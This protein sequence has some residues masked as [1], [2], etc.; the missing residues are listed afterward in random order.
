MSNK[1]QTHGR[2]AWRPSLTLRLALLGGAFVVVIV[3]CLSWVF[4]QSQQALERTARADSAVTGHIEDIERHT[5]ELRAGI[6]RV[7]TQVLTASERAQAMS[8]QLGE[9]DKQRAALMR[10]DDAVA[11]QW[12][13]V[14][15]LTRLQ[16]MMDA[17]ARWIVAPSAGSAASARATRASLGEMLS[18]LE[19]MEVIASSEL[20][21]LTQSIDAISRMA[22]RTIST[23][24]PDLT[25]DLAALYALSEAPVAA[26]QKARTDA[27]SSLFHEKGT[28]VAIARQASTRTA[29]L[30]RESAAAR[31]SA[32]FARATLEE[33][34]AQQTAL[35]RAARQQDDHRE[36]LKRLLQGISLNILIA[37]VVG[38][39]LAVV[40]WLAVMRVVLRP[41]RNLV[42]AMS[43]VGREGSWFG[44]RLDVSHDDL[45]GRLAESFNNMLEALSRSTVSTRFQNSVLDS[46]NEMLVVLDADRRVVQA[47]RAFRTA[48]GPDAGGLTGLPIDHLLSDSADGKAGHKVLR[49]AGND[50]IPI[51]VT[52]SEIPKVEGSPG[53][54]VL[55]A[56]DIRERLES[57]AA[58]RAGR[59]RF[60]DFADSAADWYWEMDAQ[61]RFSFFSDRFEKVTGVE[62][63]QLLGKTR[64]ETGIPNV[65]IKAWKAHLKALDKRV[66]FRDF[67]HPRVLKSGETVWLSI[68]GTPVYGDR[69]EFLGYRG[70]GSDVTQR[71]NAVQAVREAKE[72]ADESVRTK[73]NFLANVSHEIRTPING[74][75]GM[76]ELL[77]RSELDPRQERHARALL[78]S[79]QALLLQVNDL[80]DFARLESGKLQLELIPFS[81]EELVDEV[82][83]SHVELAAQHDLALTSECHSTIDQLL[84]DPYRIRQ[85][86]TNFISNALKFTKTGQIHIKLKS[87]PTRGNRARMVCEVIDTGIGIGP[88]R[89]DRVFDAFVQADGS[90]TREFGGTGLGLS[91]CKELIES[92][93]GEVGA[94]SVPGEGST[95]WFRLECEIAAPKRAGELPH[96]PASDSLEVDRPTWVRTP[97][98]LVVDDNDIN[99]LV[100]KEM[101]WDLGCSVETCESGEQ[102]LER[103]RS[104]AFDL[105]FMDCQMPGLDGYETTRMMR[106]LQQDGVVAAT[107]I[108]ALTANALDGDEARCI[109]A[110]MDAFITKPVSSEDLLQVLAQSLDLLADSDVSVVAPKSV[111]A[112]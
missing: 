107:P 52:I 58:L 12:T 112:V 34:E 108:V 84:G 89:I 50:G 37:L 19:K 29:S 85:V 83:A 76:T 94:H 106:Q 95:F 39:I 25:R 49:S 27:E 60:N 105:V 15:A 92:M 44:E 70:T 102:A 24:S 110:G 22:A 41:L 5:K 26:L 51:A 73:T 17:H 81:P 71:I 1:V 53:S 86:L 62:P 56:N 33:L 80:L 31:K 77:L 18:L 79:G 68:N 40:L 90:T 45:L 9:L 16:S 87:A 66:A 42:L 23:G 101:L 82:K 98:L 47:N 30:L 57:E 35:L 78:N 96:P 69:G 38:T 59:R 13:T 104:A 11:L 28:A 14:E 63:E 93:G 109:E 3:A 48:V 32:T 20:A 99:R 36:Q 8:A 75:I 4:L 55:V 65:D 2:L 67:V 64:Q 88:D 72:A 97:H 111:G 21:A 46:M 74:V 54:F 10:L 43:R 103:V 100:A 7:R 91:I 6:A 61:L